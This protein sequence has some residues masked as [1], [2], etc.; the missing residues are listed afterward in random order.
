ALMRSDNIYF[1]M[2]AIEMGVDPFIEGLEQYDFEEDIPFTYPIQKST[3][4]SDG[5]LSGEVPL[6]NTSYGQAEIEMSSLHLASIY[7]TFLNEGDML[8]PLLFTDDEH[9]Q[10][11]H[12]DILS[13]ENADLIEGILRQVV[14]DGTASTA[15]DDALEISG[16]TGTAELK[17]P[18]DEE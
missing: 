18:K 13:A 9:G 6:A 1:A 3:I 4:S 10:I 14:T 5:T 11:W 7:T 2:Q 16:K 12:K 15:N 8:K 17:K